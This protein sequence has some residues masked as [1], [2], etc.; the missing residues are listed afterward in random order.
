[1][2]GAAVSNLGASRALIFGS[3]IMHAQSPPYDLLIEKLD[4]CVKDVVAAK[5]DETAALLRIARIDLLTRAGK[6]SPEELD[7]FL[8][9]AGSE[10]CLAGDPPVREFTSRPRDP[11]F[12]GSGI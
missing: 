6:I 1:M 4:E 7:A 11:E 2:L 3:T 8:L 10:R 5:L 12:Q 9:V